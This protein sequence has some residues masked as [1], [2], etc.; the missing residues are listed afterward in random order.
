ME[1]TTTIYYRQAQTSSAPN[2]ATVDFDALNCTICYNPLHPPVFQCLAYHV[3]H[4]HGK[5][6]DRSRCHMCNMNSGYSR[7]FAVEKILDSIKVPCRNAAYGCA[8]KTA[9]HDGDAHAAACLHAPCF[10]PEPGCGFAGAGA[11]L[12][13]HLAASHGW[14]STAIRRGRA[15]D[16]QLREGA[17]RVLLLHDHD[18]GGGSGGGGQHVFLL[19]VSPAATAGMLL[20]NVFLVEPH[21]GVAPRFD[22]HVDFNC[23]GTGLRQSSEFAVRSTSLAGGLPVDCYAFVVPNVGQ[24]PATA[25]VSVIDN[26]RRRPR[27]G[28]HTQ[29]LHN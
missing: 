28:G 16:L 22:C 2:N 8:A 29:R 19:V 24:H 11:A 21:G 5:L 7:C 27:G 17:K 10:C 6:L 14:P 26:S 25:S 13:S 9:Y 1:T 12:G 23:G 3:Q 4:C 18:A 15:V 20:G